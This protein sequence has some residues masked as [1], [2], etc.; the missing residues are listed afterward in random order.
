MGQFKL[1]SRV[2]EIQSSYFTVNNYLF[3]LSSTYVSNSAFLFLCD[4]LT[5]F[6]DFF[7]FTEILKTVLLNHNVDIFI[8]IELQDLQNSLDF[9]QNRFC[10][11]L[12]CFSSLNLCSF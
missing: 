7:T 8:L 12:S 2:A 6:S 5:I 1:Q 11:S 3:F 4:L 10:I 9:L